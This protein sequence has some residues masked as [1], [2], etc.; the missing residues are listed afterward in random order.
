MALVVSDRISEEQ[1][2]AQLSLVS[3]ELTVALL[4]I[5]RAERCLNA[6]E[7]AE[8]TQDQVHA[9]LLEVYAAFRRVGDCLPPGT[10]FYRLR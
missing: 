4:A 1:S 7:S 6:F 8:A 5:E 3:E 9:E 10:H 2:D